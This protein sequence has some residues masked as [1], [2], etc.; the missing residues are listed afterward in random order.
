MNNQYK[1]TI[2]ISVNKFFKLFKYAVNLKKHLTTV[3][4]CNPHKGDF[5]KVVYKEVKNNLYIIA[6]DV[7]CL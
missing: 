3:D 4:S 2:H 1:H 5:L 7:N 6:V